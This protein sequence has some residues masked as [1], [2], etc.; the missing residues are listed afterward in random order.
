M[1]GYTNLLIILAA[2]A[3]SSFIIWALL[4]RRGSSS[5]NLLL[6]GQIIELQKQLRESLS[7]NNIRLDERLDSI[8]RAMAQSQQ[9]FGERLDGASRAMGNVQEA[10]GKLSVSTQQ[11]I[12]VGTDISKLN[13]LLRAPK[14]RG[15]MGET[16][17]EELLSQVLPT[18]YFKMGYPF[19]SGEKVDAIV[20]IGKMM[21]PIDSKFPLENFKRVIESS[22]EEERVS[23]RKLFAKDVKRHIDAIAGKYILP[24]EG[25]YDFAL[26]Y[27]PAENVY[28]EVISSLG[29][30]CDYA[31]ERRVVPVSPN[32]FYAY[33]EAIVIGLKGFEIERGAK[34]IMANLSRLKGDLGRFKEDFE[35]IGKH[36][37]NAKNKYDDA[38]KKLD[39]LD[40]KI[41]SAAGRSGQAAELKS[42]ERLLISGD[43]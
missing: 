22:T 19:K 39:N 17:L 28:Y 35:T 26:M 36:I 13:Q 41:T 3:A 27:I 43:D 42:D 2:I 30:I 23:N 40:D 38:E 29:E 12:D 25:T 21:V 31:R 6:Q 34:E 32:L 11:M 9:A 8:G 15:G 5:D 16:F 10:L 4:S 18:Q 14:F 7:E 24:D 20:T 33:L 1:D 37:T